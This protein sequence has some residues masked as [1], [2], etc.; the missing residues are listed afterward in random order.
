MNYLAIP[1]DPNDP[2]RA[3]SLSRIFRE[4]LHYD[5]LFT[6]YQPMCDDECGRADCEDCGRRIAS[7]IAALSD[8][9]SIVWE[10]WTDEDDPNLTGVLYLTRVVDRC[11][12]LA[13]YLFFDGKLTDKTALLNEMIEN[14]FRTLKLHRLTVEVPAY[15]H[16]LLRHATRKLGFHEE[17]ER[18]EA[19]RWN[20][21]WWSVHILGRLNDVRSP[22]GSEA[23]S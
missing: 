5:S 9:N 10:V 4:M 15:A 1:F 2:A 21:E 18:R 16:A 20:G 7:I 3:E 8:P 11:D 17:G 14:V 6:D 22:T 19:V 12:A 13:H 23:A